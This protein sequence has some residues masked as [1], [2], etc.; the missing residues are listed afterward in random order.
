MYR[1]LFDCLNEESNKKSIFNFKHIYITTF[2]VC[3]NI[4]TMVKAPRSLYL[5]NISHL[6]SRELFLTDLVN[7]SN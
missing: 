4:P 1:M 7:K 2:R 5:N 3:I 6:C